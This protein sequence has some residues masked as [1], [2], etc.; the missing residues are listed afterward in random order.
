MMPHA[1]LGEWHVADEQV[2]L[3]D[4]ARVRGEGRACDGQTGRERVEERVRDGTDVAPRRGI[5]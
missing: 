3:V 2:A 5:E 4:R 1:G